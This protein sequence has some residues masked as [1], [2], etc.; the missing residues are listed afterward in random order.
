VLL[1]FLVV[2]CDVE[3]WVAAI[4][5]DFSETKNMFRERRHAHS[6]QCH[7]TDLPPLKCDFVSVDRGDA[8]ALLTDVPGNVTGTN[9]LTN[10]SPPK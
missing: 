1:S 4:A 3:K 8:Q 5:L 2:H 9:I 6:Q 10:V 7:A